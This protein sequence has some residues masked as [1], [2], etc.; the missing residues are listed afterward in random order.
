LLIAFGA[1][2]LLWI[3]IFFWGFSASSPQEKQDKPKIIQEQQEKP[4]VGQ[5]PTPVEKKKNE[6]SS[7]VCPDC[8]IPMSLK[9]GKFG[10]FWGCK[11]FPTCRQTINVETGLKPG[12]IHLVDKGN[13]PLLC[14]KCNAPMVKRSGKNGEFLGCTKFPEC[15]GTRNLEARPSNP[16]K[17]D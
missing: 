7:P 12:D 10:K 8:N 11:N 1:F 2:I 14:P 6:I 15:R 5:E 17:K 13:N 3:G 4:K 16:Q 9:V